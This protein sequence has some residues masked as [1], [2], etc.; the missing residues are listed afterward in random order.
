MEIELTKN[1]AKKTDSLIT[2]ENIDE[3][4]GSIGKKSYILNCF[5]ILEYRHFLACVSR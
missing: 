5:S 2:F 1:Q 3:S 4:T